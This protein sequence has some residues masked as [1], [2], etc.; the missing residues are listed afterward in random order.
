MLTTV[1]NILTALGGVTAVFLVIAAACWKLIDSGIT[2]WLTRRVGRALERDAERYK[3]ELSRDMETYKDELA[4]SQGIERLRIEMRK[5]VAE[6]LFDRRLTAYHELFVALSE[7]PSYILSGAMQPVEH[8]VPLQ[9][10]FGR[11]QEFANTLS[12]HQLY[13]P[14]DFKQE[15]RAVLSRLLSLFTGNDWSFRPA[16]TQE[17]AVVLEINRMVAALNFKIDQYYKSLPDDLA[18]SIMRA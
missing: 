16:L 2:T 15:Y 4:R 5:A 8:R 10:V 14:L 17:D 13:L 9:D 1:Q 11:A 12:P 18:N 3:H 7:I 6:K